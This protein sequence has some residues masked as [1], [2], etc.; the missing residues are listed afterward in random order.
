M[1]RT[2]L[3]VDDSATIREM[4]SF[5]L[6]E[7]GFDVLTGGNG[8]EGLE[9][10]D[11]RPIDLVITDLNMPVV[12]GFGLIRQ[13]RTRTGYRFT[14]ILV[15]TTE[16]KETRKQEGRQAGATGWIVKPFNP[17][18]LKQVIAKVVPA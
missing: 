18:Q 8:E 7:C 11:G 10:M 1:A 12:D 9:H 14:P 6:R 2:A 3:V 16:S 15:L 17:T 13:A 5:T 4:V